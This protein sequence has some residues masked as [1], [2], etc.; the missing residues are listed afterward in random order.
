[1][2]RAHSAA[3]DEQTERKRGFEGDKKQVNA[4]TSTTTGREDVCSHLK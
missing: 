4:V 3:G 2:A 1:M